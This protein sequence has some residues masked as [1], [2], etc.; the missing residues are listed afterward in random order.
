MTARRVYIT[1]ELS[2]RV[3]WDERIVKYPTL[4]EVEKA[5]DFRIVE[6]FRFL[7]PC[8]TPEQKAVIDLLCEIMGL[9][10][11]A[12]KIKSVAPDPI[13]HKKNPVMEGRGSVE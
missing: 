5:S 3:G 6:W 2:K 11:P 9:N 8:R 4:E 10:D 13:T 7:S 12:F 1:P